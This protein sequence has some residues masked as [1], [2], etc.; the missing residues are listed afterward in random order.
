MGVSG[1]GDFVTLI[2]KCGR[3]SKNGNSAKMRKVI[4]ILKSQ[5]VGDITES[6]ELSRD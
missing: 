3:K 2:K 4:E 6:K 5:K 1:C